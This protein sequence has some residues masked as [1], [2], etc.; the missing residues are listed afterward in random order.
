MSP[1]KNKR[2]HMAGQRSICLRSVELVAH[3]C[4][5]SALMEDSRVRGLSG[6]ASQEGFLLAFAEK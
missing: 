2:A 3:R 1:G 4:L 5:D 6:L